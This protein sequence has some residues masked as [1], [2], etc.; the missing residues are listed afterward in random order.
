MNAVLAKVRWG[1][2]IGIYVTERHLVLT[3]A[4]SSPA[5]A[6]PVRTERRE[7]DAEGTAAQT[8][9]AWLGERYKDKQRRKLQVYLGLAPEQ[10]FFT[11][12]LHTQDQTT[13]P[14]VE[15]LLNSCGA[16]GAWKR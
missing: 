1:M 9:K 4:A 2:A 13:E 8:L 3:E 14:T 12:C 5:G 15:A 11:T 7:I 16:S 6:V 10:V